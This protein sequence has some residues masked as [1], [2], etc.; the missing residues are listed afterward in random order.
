[1]SYQL[2]LTNNENYYIVKKDSDFTYISTN[3]YD[4][5]NI[6]DEINYTS[7][8]KITHD[9]WRPGDTILFSFD[10]LDYFKTIKQTNPELFI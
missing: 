8:Y 2:V 1:M 4:L 6:V 3:Y 5:P 10:S 9:K 7:N